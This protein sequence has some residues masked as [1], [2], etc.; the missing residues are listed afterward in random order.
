M[1]SKVAQANE[2]SSRERPLRWLRAGPRPGTGQLTPR[3][4]VTAMSGLVLAM[5]L[6]QLDNMIVAP[7][8][9]TIVGELGGL[10][11]LSW[12]VTA[13]ILA[14]TVATPIW[15]K[16]GDIF[17]HKH[18]FMASIVLFL[19]GSAL[20]GVSQNMTAAGAVPRRAGPRRRRP[21]RG[22]H[23][24]DRDARLAARTRQVHGRD[25]GGDAGRPDR[26]AAHR[27]VHHRPRLVAV[28]LLRQPAARHRLAVRGL[29]DAAPLPR[30]RRTR[31]RWSSTGGVPACSASGSAPWC[32]PSPGVATSTRGPR[33][34]S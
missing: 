32:W 13:Y 15:G 8:L 17:G 26:R 11:H 14:S 12:V 30:A 31:A 28:G 25:D 10:N 24:G 21:D 2:S 9:P 23:V 4:I 6:A 27:R 22:H 19:I 18:T 1:T 33:G 34:R 16:L 20:C 7:A 3:Q 5:L 29:V